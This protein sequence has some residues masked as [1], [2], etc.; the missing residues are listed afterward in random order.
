MRPLAALRQKNGDGVTLQ[1]ARLDGLSVVLL[2]T[3]CGVLEEFLGLVASD[4]YDAL[5]DEAEELLEDA[6][7]R[8]EENDRKTV[9]PRDL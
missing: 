8:A 2:G 5:D 6:A 3:P 9:Q 7:R 1:V 4:F